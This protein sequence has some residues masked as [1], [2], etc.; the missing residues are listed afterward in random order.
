MMRELARCS[1][2][3]YLGTPPRSAVDHLI[4]D[5]D[6]YRLAAEGPF[7]QAPKKSID[8]LVM[9]RTALA[10]SGAGQCATGPTSEAGTR[11][12]GTPQP[13]ESSGNVI[14][15][16]VEVMS[17]RNSLIRSEE[18]VLT[19]VVGLDGV[20]VIATADAVLRG[21]SNMPNGS[22]TWSSSSRPG[23]GPRRWSTAA[24]T[25]PGASTRAPNSGARY[26]VK[27]ICVN[28]ARGCRCRSTSTAP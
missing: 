7:A 14:E 9:E 17:T 13:Q 26:Q 19:T 22:R 2:A 16:P 20:I 12:V 27:R 6:F 11:G 4:S 25:V 24:S 8:H 1:S 21:G 5:L 23:T 18:T 10:A 15:G 3:G 28:P